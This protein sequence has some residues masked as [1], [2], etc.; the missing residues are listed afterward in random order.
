MEWEKRVVLAACD[1]AISVL[2]K[3]VERSAGMEVLLAMCSSRQALEWLREG[4]VH[5]AGS[6]LRDPDTGE[7]NLPWVRRLFPKKDTVVVTF[8]RWDEGIVVRPGNPKRVKRVEDL[9][10][11]DVK[12]VNR[13]IGSGSR[14]LLDTRLAAIGLEAGRVRG[15]AREV[16][17]HLEAAQLVLSA[18]VDCCLATRL[19]ARVFGLDFV[20]LDSERFDLV[21]LRTHLQLPAVRAL[22]ETLNRAVLRR[23]L[24]VLAGYD[25]THTGTVLAS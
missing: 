3:E 13:D 1:P 24:E 8:A 18:E 6:H 21:T 15:Y 17:T 16:A 9:A 11:K 5:I 4:R 7:F 25:T 14:L 2:Q 19:A 22:F 20:P 12:F 10:R 23:Q